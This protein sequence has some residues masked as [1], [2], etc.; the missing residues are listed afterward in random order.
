MVFRT[1][2]RMSATG[3]RIKGMV[4]MVVGVLMIVA[5]PILF[6]IY[7]MAAVFLLAVLGVVAILSGLLHVHRGQRIMNR[8]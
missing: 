8:I 5:S 4:L 7:H 6:I 2:A 3:Y 1:M